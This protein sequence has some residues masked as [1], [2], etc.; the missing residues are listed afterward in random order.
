[1][2]AHAQAFPRG[3]LPEHN[4]TAVLRSW[5]F[6]DPTAAAV[7][8]TQ[9]D[10]GTALDQGDSRLTQLAYSGGMLWTGALL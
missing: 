4:G 9:P 5:S 8:V 7:V 10:G 2:R 1:M 3:G 6:A